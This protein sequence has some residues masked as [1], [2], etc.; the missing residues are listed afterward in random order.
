MFLVLMMEGD[1]T[2]ATNI[3]NIIAV[4]LISNYVANN[5]TLF[6]RLGYGNQE[7]L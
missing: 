7:I 3:Q 5:L 1:V 4:G 2:L 6:G